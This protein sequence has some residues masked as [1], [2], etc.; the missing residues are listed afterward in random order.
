MNRYKYA[1]LDLSY[2]MMRNLF[3]VSRGKG[4]GEY[5]SGDLIKTIIWTINKMARD[6]GITADKCIMVY[7]KWSKEY[8][9]YY[10]TYLLKGFYKST[11]EYMTP[12]LL[13][14]MKQD[15]SVTPEEIHEAELKCYQNQVK[16]EAKWGMVRDLKNLGVPCLGLDGYEY[17]D[18]A[19]LAACMLYGEDGGKKSV[20]VTKDSDLQYSLTPQMDYFKI[21]TSGSQPKIITYDEMYST[22]PKSLTD[23]G[24]S[25]YMYKAFMDSLGM[26]HN[27]MTKTKKNYVDPEEAILRLLDGDYSVVDDIEVFNKQM[28]SFDI[29]KFPKLD[30]A[31]SIISKQ[32][33]TVGKL[34]GLDD[35]HN[36]CEKYKISGISDKYYSEFIGRFDQK[37]FTE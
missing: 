10:R 2:I 9:G 12:E 37:L 13:E 24:V 14:K 11:R 15:P 25:L 34:G 8:Q 35:F 26:G 7:D 28:E 18:L 3:S 4:V 6:F 33:G 27:D 21:P 5:T 29:S 1:I 23:R 19:Y 20:I 36:F 30:E 22:I 17:D 16:Y 31:K 32:F